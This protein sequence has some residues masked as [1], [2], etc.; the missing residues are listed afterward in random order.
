MKEAFYPMAGYIARGNY[1]DEF[2]DQHGNTR[3]HWEGFSKILR[4]WEPQEFTRREEQLDRIIRDNGI[5]YNIYAEPHG[6]S[7]PWT[8]DMLPI[9]FSDQEWNTIG[10]ALAQRAEL[11]NLIYKDLYGPQN[12][13]KNGLLPT[14][15][16]LANPHFCRPCHQLSINQTHPMHLYANDMARSPDG[17]WWILS[18]RLEAASG[19]GYALENRFI[20]SRILPGVMRQL[21]VKRLNDFISKLCA[22]HEKLA[23]RPVEN[24]RIVLLTPGP[25]NETFFEQSY[26]ARNL[27]Y[28][29][30]EGADLTVRNN[31]VYLKTIAEV[32]EVNVI[33]R[34]VD[35]SWCDPLELRN[36]SLLG[37]P[38][39]VDV[40][41]AGNVTIANALGSS[42][43]ETPALP[44]FLP[45]LCKYFLGEE[46]KIPSVA[47][48]WCGQKKEMDFVL[49]NLHQLVLKPSFRTGRG[50]SIFGANL[51]EHSLDR[52]KAKIR[53]HPH[54]YCA[55]ELVTQATTP[56]YDRGHLHP[57]HFLLRTYSVPSDGRWQIMPGGLGRIA[58]DSDPVNV[59]MQQGGESKDVWVLS[60]ES[61]P[62][63]QQADTPVI[64][65]NPIRR[66]GFDIPSRVA[67]N[68]FWLGRYVERTEGMARVL[69]ILIEH[70]LE[71]GI[72]N[73]RSSLPLFG[74]FTN[75]K[76]I[77]SLIN[78]KTDT[79]D[80]ALSAKHLALQMRD[81]RNP[82][83]L[84]CNL[85]YLTA[86]AKRVKERLSHQTWQQ[87]L[88]LSD[89]TRAITTQRDVLG[90][91]TSQIL[92]DTLDLLAGFSGLAM[93]N[94]TRGQNWIFLDLGRRIERS[95]VLLNL[96]GCTM[97][98]KTN[99]EED[100]LKQFLHCADSSMTYRR[101]YLTHIHAEAVFD[102]LAME[103]SNPRSLIFQAE[104]ILQHVKALPHNVLPTPPTR[105]DRKALT[106]A[107]T[108]G[109]AEPEVML[110]VDKKNH[111]KELMKFHDVLIKNLSEL[112]EA[113]TQQYFAHT[114]E[115]TRTQQNRPST[116]E[117]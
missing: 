111:R 37:V 71:Q 9:I 6:E 95:F 40:I 7:R 114:A 58:S 78:K 16:I 13:L 45:T 10:D 41:R 5:T 44:A 81:R 91:E 88:R 35:T 115:I 54:A 27:G 32:K 25:A 96:L 12:L 4:N 87:L 99:N 89:L 83:S 90:V 75:E 60:S 69:K 31:K 51:S 34:H 74:Y 49:E 19:L 17:S 103:K 21:E 26:L 63:S 97:E 92:E 109:L 39:L 22:S 55:Q 116:Q 28:T 94:M 42:L 46:L 57:K 110:R 82:E 73:D 20:S 23:P 15:M 61:Y 47:T 100:S 77:A 8:M 56:I 117:L 3:P 76:T 106:I 112:A 64:Q 105:I 65:L 24:P 72:D 67:D 113:I 80:L 104:Q 86:A 66:G 43:L 52:W 38:G 108:I 11:L 102:L 62:K 30:A 53:K 79:L 70:L 59:S 107:N 101:R 36:D 85:D 68:F 48:W 29:L 18:D 98:Y 14:W 50:Q 2:V 84:A 93:E 1:Y 33:I